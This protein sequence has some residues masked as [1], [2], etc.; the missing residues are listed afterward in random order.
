MECIGCAR[1]S[2]CTSDMSLLYC[3]WSRQASH[4]GPVVSLL[5]RVPN[6][7]ASRIVPHFAHDH[8]PARQLDVLIGR[9]LALVLVWRGEAAWNSQGRVSSDVHRGGVGDDRACVLGIMLVLSHHRREWRSGAGS[10]SARG[11]SR[12][13]LTVGFVPFERTPGLL[14]VPLGRVRDRRHNHH[15]DILED[16]VVFV[17]K[18]P[19]E[20]LR[21]TVCGGVL[22]PTV[23]AVA[24]TPMLGGPEK[25]V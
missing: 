18:L 22:W 20:V 17:S 7:Q 4:L 10:R 16:L 14:K 24:S 19:S 2:I 21:F 6:F 12:L 25:G 15:V 23:F 9:G 1:L 11:L 5:P 3:L 8:H 13:R